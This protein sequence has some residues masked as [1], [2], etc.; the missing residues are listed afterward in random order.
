MVKRAYK[1]RFYP[2]IE[3][4]A[5]LARTFG[6]VR[7]VYNWSL[8]LR[9]DA[10]YDRQER[11]NYHTN[12]SR[13]TLLKKQDDHSWLNEVSSVPL[14]QAL[15]NLGTAFQN[16]W[17]KRARYPNFKKCRA[18]QSAEYTRSAFKWDG[19][20]LLLAKM[21][22]PLDIRWSRCFSGK[23]STVTVSRDPAGRY[24]VSILV[25]ETIRRKRK[26][27][28]SA[29]IDL[30]IKDV[31]VTSDGFKSGAPK[32]FRKH[33][34]RLARAQRRADHKR[35]EK[36]KEKARLKVAKIHAKIA[37]CR[38]DFT[39]KL[40]TK[41]INE[42]QV[43]FTETLAVKNMI[44][45]HKLA[46]SIADSG[47]GEFLRQLQYKAEWYGRT[48]VGIN[49]WYPSSKRCSKCG[50]VNAVLKLSDREWT[51]PECG[52]THDR[53]VNAALNVKAVGQ[54]VLAFGEDVS[55]VLGIGCLQ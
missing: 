40:S 18:R 20:Q 28:K 8:R 53:D 33:E 47:W 29:G 13:L 42:N 23:P 52:I 46:K 51:C 38:K 54:A 39:H 21:R 45:N 12:S 43:I 3:Q 37:D 19:K 24:F 36:N 25:E 22:E 4:A 50:W 17:T 30:G 32:Y 49:R 34:K 9:Q 14:Q 55:P 27:K 7:Y 2:T 16:F 1:Y 11:I 6:C 10:W 5:Q 35:G 44:R 31:C 41:L 15:R 48:V 26:T